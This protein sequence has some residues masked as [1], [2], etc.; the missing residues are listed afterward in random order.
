MNTRE[1]DDQEFEQLRQWLSDRAVDRERRDPKGIRWL[2]FAVVGA[3][4]IAAALMVAG[5]ADAAEANCPWDANCISVT[6]ATAR[7]DGSPLEVSKIAGHRIETA[8][9]LSGPWTVL[10]TLTMPTLTYRHQPV[11][12]T[13]YYRAVTVLATSKESDP[14]TSA[15]ATTVEPAPNPPTLQVV[16][17]VGYQLNLGSNNRIYFSRAGTVP[18][19]RECQAGMEVMGKSVIKSRDWLTLDAGKTRPRQVFAMCERQS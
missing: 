2:V 19:G 14:V 15:P 18:L 16:D 8:K 9:S 3:C 7:V 17:N 12:G 1:D 6:V 13:N 4:L 11:S 10:T 5:S